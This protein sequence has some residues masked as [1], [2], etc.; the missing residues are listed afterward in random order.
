MT[1]G[2]GGGRGEGI[3]LCLLP[4]LHTKFLLPGGIC[5]ENKRGKAVNRDEKGKKILIFS[6]PPCKLTWEADFWI[7][8][9]A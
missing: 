3:G 7:C 4:S 6:L 5:K 9:A 1:M 2:I 8:Y